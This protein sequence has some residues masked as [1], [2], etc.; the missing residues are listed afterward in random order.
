MFLIMNNWLYLCIAY[1]EIHR[2]NI[3]VIILFKM[4][5]ILYNVSAQPESGPTER[6]GGNQITTV[7]L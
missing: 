3:C 4:V 2:K 1:N 7:I 6:E 5:L